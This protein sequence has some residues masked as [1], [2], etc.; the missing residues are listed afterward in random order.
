MTM[1]PKRR[2]LRLESLADLSSE[3]ERIEQA[4]REGRLETTGQWTAGQILAHLAAWI[5]YGYEG[6]PMQKPPLLLR[7]FLRWKLPSYLQH[8]MGA[9]VRIPGVPGGTY[10][11]DRM[12]VA[13]AAERLHRAIGRLSAKEPCPHES[14]AFGAMTFE[15]RVRLNLR[16]AEL[17]L[18]FLRY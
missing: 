17:H 3:L 10:G 7:W 8:G 16:H 4:D 1:D 15:D 13:R 5:E 12:E 14:P 2:S 18:G 6:Y 11:I 9:G